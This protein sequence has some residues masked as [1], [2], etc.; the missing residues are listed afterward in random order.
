MAETIHP[1]AMYHLPP[2]VT[3]PP[4]AGDLPIAKPGDSSDV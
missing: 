2:F 1:A 3:A 4:P